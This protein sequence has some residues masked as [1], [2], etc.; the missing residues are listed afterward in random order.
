MMSTMDESTRRVEHVSVTGVVQGVGFRPFVFRLATELGLDGEVGNDATGVFVTIA[1]PGPACDEFVRR[2]TTDAPPIALVESVRRRPAELRDGEIAGGFRIV[3]SVASAGERTLVPPDTAV[4]DDCLVELFDPRD[5]RFRHPFITCT[6]CGP[7]F[8][9]IRSLPYDRPATTMA[10]FDMCRRCAAEYADPADRRYH[11][12]PIGCHD[13]GPRLSSSYGGDPI[14]D[15]A[16]AIRAGDTVAVKGL[17]GFHLMCD[18][19]DDAAID[20]LRRRKHRPDKPFAVLVPDLGTARMIA[21]V[22]DAEAHL[23]TSPARP[24]VLLRARS[25]SPLSAL[26]AP[27]NPLV[28]VMLAYTPVHHLLF[29]TGLGPLVC[30]SGNRSGEP[31][32]HRDDDVEAVLA[33]LADGV[34]SHDRPIEVPCDDSVVRVVGRRLLPVR[35]ARGYAP[36]PVSWAD[37]R[38]AVLAVGGE[39]KSTCC[40][41]SPHHAWVSQHIGEQGTLATLEAFEATVDRFTRTYAVTPDVV[42]VDAHPGYATSQ[43]GRRSDI[44]D[45]VE[46]Q[47]HHAHVA[48]AMA[49][50]R[51]DP[52]RPVLGIVFDGTGYGTDGTIWG[53]EVLLA[54][55]TGFERIAHL[56]PVPLPGG[57]AAITNP[58]RVALAHLHAAGIDWSDDLAPV[59]SLA[60]DGDTA[61]RLLHHQLTTGFSC[62]ATS[63]MGRLFDAVAAL[64]GLRQRISFEAQAAIELEVAAAAAG[65]V[66]RGYRLTLAP[67]AH[68]AAVAATAPLV[69]AVVDDLRTG[70]PTGD[71]AAGF[72]AAVVALAADVVDRWGDRADHV[73]LSGGV[74]QNALLTEWTV[75]RLA[76]RGVVALTHHL[77][78]PNDGGLA[79]GQAFVA[80]HAPTTTRHRPQEV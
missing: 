58:Y 22:S 16:S 12:Q 69:R 29:A 75:E 13:C 65:R 10:G 15:V 61:R 71:I 74:F 62:V 9:I 79:L 53:G 26:V 33:P 41:A 5:R 20:R 19:T 24:I 48:A 44:G 43:W 11:A 23:L 49:E 73:V 25:T 80:A 57:D 30:T 55:A 63:S 47:H 1:G 70:V 3:A 31:I 45:V 37:A 39:L 46:V 28:G 18:A 34:V 35:R 7:R 76:E 60:D 21:D 78:P 52:H 77:V 17:G 40:V 32:V 4:C 54:T 27:G 2:I 8:T 64:V 36:L 56:A 38:R 72:H 51:L 50:H 68:G 59:R 6:N 66:D 14:A 67:S 42:A